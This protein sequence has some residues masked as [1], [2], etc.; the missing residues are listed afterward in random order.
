[1]SL[2]S[3]SAEVPRKGTPCERTEVCTKFV[4]LRARILRNTQLWYN[5]HIWSQTRQQGISREPVPHASAPTNFDRESKHRLAIERMFCIRASVH[6]TSYFSHVCPQKQS[7]EASANKEL[8]QGSRPHRPEGPIF[9]RRCI[10]ND[11]KRG[12]SNLIL[13]LNERNKQRA[14]TSNNGGRKTQHDQP[15][16]L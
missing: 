6:S 4:W 14:D 12:V 16:A 10:T 8:N 13:T 9:C 7:L 3:E 11:M 5:Q 2:M 15:S 1:M